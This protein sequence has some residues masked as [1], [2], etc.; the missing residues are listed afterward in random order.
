MSGPDAASPD[1]EIYE[2]KKQVTCPFAST[3]T[4]TQYTIIKKDQDN[5][6]KSCHWKGGRI[7]SV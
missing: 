7:G 1:P 6:N 5:H 2:I 4:Y 3:H